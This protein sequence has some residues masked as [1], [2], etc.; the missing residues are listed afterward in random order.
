MIGSNIPILGVHFL[1]ELLVNIVA[2]LLEGETPLAPDFGKT[3]PFLGETG[4]VLP[5]AK[6]PYN[7]ITFFCEAL[8]DRL[9]EV[10]Q[11]ELRSLDRKLRAEY[12][13]VEQRYPAATLRGIWIGLERVS[14]QALLQR[15]DQVVVQ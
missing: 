4:C 11:Q 7:C 9:D 12:E 8:E 6:R 3:C 13:L 10:R 1:T 5:V 14:G 15:R 2:F